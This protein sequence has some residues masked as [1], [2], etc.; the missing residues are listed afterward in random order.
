MVIAIIGILAAMLLPSLARAKL[1]GTF[2]VCASNEKQ[3]LLA[4]TMY[5]QDNNDNLLSTS[6]L[7]LAGGGWWLGP[8]G[9]GIVSGIT[10]DQAMQRDTTGLEASPLW[11]YA[12][13]VGAAHCPGDMRTKHL[14]PGAGWAYDSY[15]LADSMA[16]GGEWNTG[17]GQYYVKATAIQDPADGFVFI[18]ES[19]PRGYNEGTWAF[20]LSPPG[21]VDGF[22]AFHGV[23]TTFGFADSHVESH[24]WVTP[25]TVKAATQFAQGVADFYWSGGNVMINQ[26]FIWVWNHFEWPNWKPL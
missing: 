3:L 20:D 21:W 2:A 12:P 13:A 9:G 23:V 14:R 7:G 10:T 5:Y 11:K 1:K 19:D 8:S 16:G 24:K 26:D 15:S 4:W 25:S 22:A 17:P 6:A 18:E